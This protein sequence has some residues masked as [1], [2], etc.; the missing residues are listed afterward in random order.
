MAKQKIKKVIKGLE[1]ASKT[2]ASQAKT[3]KSIK[4]KDGGSVP[5]NVAN[6]AL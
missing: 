2:H 5:S 3:L 1:K 4:M 6:R